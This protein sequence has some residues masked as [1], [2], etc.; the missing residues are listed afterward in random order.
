MT[1]KY[2]LSGGAGGTRAIAETWLSFSY[3]TFLFLYIYINV[4]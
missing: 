2:I 4:F 3:A 1:E